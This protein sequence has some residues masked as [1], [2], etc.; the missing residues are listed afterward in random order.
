M[1]VAQI[2]PVRQ[3]SIRSGVL[4]FVVGL[5]ALIGAPVGGKLTEAD[6]GGWRYLSCFAG[7]CMGVAAAVFG[8]ARMVVLGKGVRRV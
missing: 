4:F 1:L 8:V 6:G 5:A 7:A 2:S 3:I